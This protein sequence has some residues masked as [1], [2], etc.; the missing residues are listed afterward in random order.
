[1]SW[2]GN[3]MWRKKPIAVSGRSRRMRCG[4]EH[5][6]V[7]VDPDEAGVFRFGDGD[8]A[9]AIVHELVGLPVPPS[10]FVRA[11]SECISGQSVRLEK[12]W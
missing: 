7:V 2:G 5:Q 12:P 4:R 8:L 10:N 3:G 11:D 1:M 6:L 9:E